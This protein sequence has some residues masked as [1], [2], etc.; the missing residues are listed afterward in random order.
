MVHP[1]N[2]STADPARIVNNV[3]LINCLLIFAA[4]GLPQLCGFMAVPA[5]VK[6][7]ILLWVNTI[8]LFILECCFSIEC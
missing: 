4:L 2:I 7:H 6:V 8:M 3:F 5:E 1:L